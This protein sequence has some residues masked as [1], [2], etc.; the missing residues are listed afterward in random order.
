MPSKYRLI[1]CDAQYQSLRR[2]DSY[3]KEAVHLI[4]GLDD[5][6]YRKLLHISV[7][8]TERSNSWDSALK[9]IKNR[10]VEKG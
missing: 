5:N 8:P 10:G 7:N 6:N 2:G 9:D 3:S 4:Y 1:Y